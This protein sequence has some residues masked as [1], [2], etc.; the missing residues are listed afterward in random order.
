MPPTP[1]SCC[2]KTAAPGK[3]LCQVCRQPCP[4]APYQCMCGRWFDK[5]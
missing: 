4:N 1:C 2:G 5:R 3:L